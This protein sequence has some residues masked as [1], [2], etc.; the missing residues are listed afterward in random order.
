[1]RRLDAIIARMEEHFARTD[2]SGLNAADIAFHREVCHTS[3]NEIVVTLWETLARHVRIVFGRE[4]SRLLDRRAIV[5]EHYELRDA[6]AAAN[7]ATL[8]DLVDRHIK[9]AAYGDD[10]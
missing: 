8:D 10:D 2:W 3:G 7:A 9:G 5:D 4:T 1:M 6:L